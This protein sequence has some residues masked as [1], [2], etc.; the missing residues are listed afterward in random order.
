M[1][2]KKLK[3]MFSILEIEPKIIQ[4]YFIDNN[5]YQNM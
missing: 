5:L 4:L 1:S 3:I 2:E